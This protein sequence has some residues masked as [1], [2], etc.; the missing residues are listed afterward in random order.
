MILITFQKFKIQTHI[1][2]ICCAVFWFLITDILYY[3]NV[4]F[5]FILSSHQVPEATHQHFQAEYQPTV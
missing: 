3:T 4:V 1:T 5:N 2:L